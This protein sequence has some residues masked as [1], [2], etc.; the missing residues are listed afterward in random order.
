MVV[1]VA[2]VQKDLH[3]GF[4]EQRTA[5]ALTLWLSA[6]IR[7]CMPATGCGWTLCWTPG[8]T[9]VWKKK[10]K[11][12][13]NHLLP[14][15]HACCYTN[16]PN[17]AFLIFFTMTVFHFQFLVPM[18]SSS[19][20]SKNCSL[21]WQWHFNV[22]MSA[23]YYCTR[24]CPAC[25]GLSLHQGVASLT[26]YSAL[27]QH[28]SSEARQVEL[29]RDN[30]FSDEILNKNGDL[31]IHTVPFPWTAVLSLKDWFHA[32]QKKILLIF[33]PQVSIVP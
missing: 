14:W 1:L 22:S 12:K 19:E 2:N 25:A 8:C 13:T 17:H 20:T 9:A 3:W 5:S 15:V 11:K 23:H 33:W 27:G 32:K 26:A 4:F 6:W 21:I 10:K 24:L 29:F 18:C 31:A 16:S 30:P 28:P 7:R